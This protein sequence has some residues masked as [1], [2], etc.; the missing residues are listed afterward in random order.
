MLKIIEN[1][2]YSINLLDNDSVVSLTMVLVNINTGRLVFKTDFNGV[3]SD[4]TNKYG[5]LIESYTDYEVFLDLFVIENDQKTHYATISSE[6]ELA[7]QFEKYDDDEYS[8]T[9][10][11]KDS[12]VLEIILISEDVMKGLISAQWDS[13]AL[14]YED[15]QINISKLEALVNLNEQ[16]LN[17]YKKVSSTVAVRGTDIEKLGKALIDE[18]NF[19]KA[20]QGIYSMMLIYD[21]LSSKI[22]LSTVD[23]R[24][25]SA[26]KALVRNGNALVKLIDGKG[27][28]FPFIKE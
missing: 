1:S 18:V 14:S 13:Y 25:Y 24:K 7:R 26:V 27:K 19:E 4:F 11:T 16:K 9:Y 8:Y 6:N 12:D 22:T 5:D 17:S 23:S 28:G 3:L 2:N 15:L 10:A 21:D 20:M